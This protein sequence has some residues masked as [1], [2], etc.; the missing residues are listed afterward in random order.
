MENLINH[1]TKYGTT[2][3]GL[4]IGRSTFYNLLRNPTYMGFTKVPEFNEEEEH[5]VPGLHEAII[6]E[7]LFHQVQAVL[8]KTSG[9]KLHSLC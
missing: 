6:G 9:K 3:K 2:D 7:N 8:K 5:Y 4:K 1:E